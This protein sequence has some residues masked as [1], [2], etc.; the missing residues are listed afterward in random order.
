MKQYFISQDKKQYRANLHAHST[1]SDGM[2]S[3]EELKKIYRTQGYSIL[4][5]TD[6]EHPKSH[7]HLS[8]PDFLML[9][10]YEAYIRT[11]ANAQFDRYEPEVHLNLFARDPQNETMICFNE[12]YCKYIDDPAERAALRRVGSE[13]PREYSVPYVNEFI[14]TAVQNGYLV[15][16]NHPVWSLED[17]ECI[18]SYEN[19]FSLE[20]QNFSAYRQNGIEY[21]GALYDKMLRRRKHVFC[22]AGDDNHNK[23]PL[24]CP[25]TDSF[26]AFTMILSDELSYDAVISA[27]ERG[28]MYA[29]MGPL[30]HEIS[31]E[32]GVVHVE[33]SPASRIVLYTGSKTPKFSVP[34]HGKSL[35]SADLKL[36]PIAPYFR[37]A[38]IDEEGKIASTRGFFRSEFLA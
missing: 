27:M 18:L 38:V 29:S 24:S 8:D 22:H 2:L 36:D 11:N 10:G 28:E 3:P 13:R 5:I 6:H 35:T 34:E 21:S 23:T 30:I 15:A 1:L 31:L 16:Y 7:A 4:A 32:N 26:G 20:I 25:R 33:C 9:T 37:V 12:V 17:E 19:I 14:R